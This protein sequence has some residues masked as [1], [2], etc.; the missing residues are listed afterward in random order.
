MLA[1]AKELRDTTGKNVKV[2]RVGLSYYALHPVTIGEFL[3]Y[4]NVPEITEDMEI[5]FLLDH[6][7]HPEITLDSLDAG[8]YEKLKEALFTAS[9]FSQDVDLV[10]DPIA[11][12]TVMAV[13][14]LI[15]KMDSMGHKNYRIILINRIP[16]VIKSITTDEYIQYRAT[17]ESLLQIPEQHRFIKAAELDS[18]FAKAHIIYP[19]LIPDE[20]GYLENL[21]AA[22]WKVSGFSQEVEIV[23]L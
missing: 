17:T 4:R 19:E 6:V 12:Q 16:F 10:Y 15:K 14:E 5:K 8:T 9:G 23:E 21:F 1:K 13:D 2:V 7:A 18:A 22:L 11:A 3:E 20:A